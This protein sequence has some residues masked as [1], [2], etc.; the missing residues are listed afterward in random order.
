M[1]IQRQAK[2]Y[3]VIVQKKYSALVGGSLYKNANKVIIDA[4]D[5][6]INLSS[7]KKVTSTGGS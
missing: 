1:A 5:G 3:K 2:S 6:D 7:N 4:V